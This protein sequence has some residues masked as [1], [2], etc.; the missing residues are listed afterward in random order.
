MSVGSRARLPAGLEEA[1][2][3]NGGW[4]CACQ[5]SARL[6]GCLWLRR[7]TGIAGA[8]TREQLERR[9]GAQGEERLGRSG[10]YGSGS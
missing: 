2:A 5:G 3:R 9:G 10:V 8:G 7:D 1:A 6:P 4:P